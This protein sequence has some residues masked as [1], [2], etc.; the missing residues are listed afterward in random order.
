MEQA[1][2]YSPM[3]TQDL[4]AVAHMS[5]CEDV[6]PSHLELVPTLPNAQHCPPCEH[7]FL[8]CHVLAS[9][10]R[11]RVAWGAEPRKGCCFYCW[12]WICCWICRVSKIFATVSLE[13]ALVQCRGWDWQSD[14]YQ[15][16]SPHR[17]ESWTVPGM[18]PGLVL[19]VPVL[20]LYK[21]LEP[22]PVWCW[23]W[24]WQFASC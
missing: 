13:L 7:L 23:G 4:G 20:A 22:V 19:L 3:L 10:S 18:E 21:S 2:L 9:G 12:I 5:A 15:S 1:V 6:Q 24:D 14:D 11:Q 16:R 17:R 8:A